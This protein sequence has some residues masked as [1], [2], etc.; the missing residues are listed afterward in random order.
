[1]SDGGKGDKRRPEDQQ[2]FRDNYDK[3]FGNKKE[4]K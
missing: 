2:K 4:N 1:M 3:I